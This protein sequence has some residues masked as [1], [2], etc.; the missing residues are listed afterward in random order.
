MASK[1]S[2]TEGLLFFAAGQDPPVKSGLM[3]GN[4]MAL[5]VSSLEVTRP[6][7]EST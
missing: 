7:T 5:G 1:P 2:Q 3:A 4:S 6:V